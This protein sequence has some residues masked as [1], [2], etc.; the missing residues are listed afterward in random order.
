MAHFTSIDQLVAAVTEYEFNGDDVLAVYL[1]H[2]LFKQLILLC[3]SNKKLMKKIKANKR[4]E[5]ADLLGAYRICFKVDPTH[6]LLNGYKDNFEAAAGVTL[7]KHQSDDITNMGHSAYGES[8]IANGYCA[9]K[10]A[11]TKSTRC[12]HIRLT[13][14][15]DTP[16]KD[17]KMDAAKMVDGLIDCLT[18]ITPTT[19]PEVKELPLTVPM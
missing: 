12:P 10:I 17:G 13:Y 4:V 1:E 5:A 9:V 19:A 6:Q 8:D 3:Y 16:Y 2:S 14:K 18:S 7:E 11:V 15:A